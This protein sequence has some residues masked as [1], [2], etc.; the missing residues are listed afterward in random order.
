MK[1]II[2]LKSA[3]LFLLTFVFLTV[4]LSFKTDPPIYKKGWIDLNKNGKKDIYE[5]S[6]QPIEARLSDLISQMT[7]EEKT[8]QMATLY[9]YKRILQDSV[10]PP[11][12]NNEQSQEP[13][14][15]IN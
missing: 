9:G 6:T 3:V 14:A 2:R 10:P 8:C 13:H 5:D 1:L 4:C 15:H 7:L 11:A 12:W